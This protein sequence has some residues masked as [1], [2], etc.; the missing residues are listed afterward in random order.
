MIP[1][2]NAKDW[3]FSA[4]IL[5]WPL[6][7]ILWFLSGLEIGLTVPSIK[8]KQFWRGEPLSEIDWAYVSK[9]WRFSY[10]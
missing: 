3:N 4:W 7:T 10:V 5:L 1:F 8:P 2:G 6:Y 9:A